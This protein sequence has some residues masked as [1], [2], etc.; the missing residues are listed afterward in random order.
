LVGLEAGC[1]AVLELPK[2][3]AED[4]VVQSALRRAVRVYGLSRYR[5]DAP[6]VSEANVPAALVL[7][8]GNVNEERIRRG[9]ELLGEVLSGTPT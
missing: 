3:V 6:R 4:D 2:G 8:F 7:G 5:V 9:V 1:H